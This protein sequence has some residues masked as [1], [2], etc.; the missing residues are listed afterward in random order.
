MTVSVMRDHMS[1]LD[2]ACLGYR[3]AKGS[4]FFIE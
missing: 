1:H 3:G 2:G 4:P